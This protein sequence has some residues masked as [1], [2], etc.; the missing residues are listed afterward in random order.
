MKKVIIVILLP[1]FT[2]CFF[3]ACNNSSQ[4][5][6]EKQTTALPVVDSSAAIN[7]QVETSEKMK[8]AIE[9]NAKTMAKKETVLAGTAANEATKQAWFK[10]DVYSDSTGIRKI[11]LYPHPGIS[12]RSE[13]FYYANGKMFFTFIA[14]AGLENEN[15][16]ENMPGKEFHF[17]A[18]KLI[19]YDDKSRD[20]ES[21]VAEEKKKYELTLPL[22]A[23]E[24]YALAGGK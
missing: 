11:K 22:E 14:D 21:N 9:E 20:K 3:T 1:V 6:T 17:I 12:K 8:A 16:D 2:V 13:E 5:N 19:R 23:E 15:A 18:E 24:L 4:T 7:A 10:I